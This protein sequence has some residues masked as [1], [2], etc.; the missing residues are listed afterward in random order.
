MGTSYKS[1]QTKIKSH[2]KNLYFIK[3]YLLR[4]F[5]DKYSGHYIGRKTYTICTYFIWT[6]ENK[7]IKKEKK[8]PKGQYQALAKRYLME[9]LIKYMEI[10]E[11]V[12]WI[13]GSYR[14]AIFSSSLEQPFCSTKLTNSSNDWCL[15]MYIAP[16]LY[17]VLSKV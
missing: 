6:V 2:S 16:K 12:S 11:N 7:L 1:N 3:S 17:W 5:W 4:C 15:S 14:L 8:H 13:R 10:S 9:I